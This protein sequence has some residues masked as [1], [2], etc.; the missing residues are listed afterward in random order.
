M[1][2][3]RYD[4]Y[5]YRFMESESVTE[6]SASEVGQYLLLLNKSWTLKKDATLPKDP[7]TLAKYARVDK[8]SDRVLKMFEEVQTPDGTRLRNETMY[9]EWIKALK[10]VQSGRNAAAVRWHK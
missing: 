9:Q 8:V 2:L 10:R 6:M 4:F 3:E 7:Q 5:V 1:E